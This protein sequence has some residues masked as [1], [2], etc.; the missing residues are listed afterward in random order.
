MAGFAPVAALELPEVSMTIALVLV[1]LPPGCP[2][3]LLSPLC[4]TAVT[5][6]LSAPKGKGSTRRRNGEQPAPLGASRWAAQRCPGSTSTVRKRLRLVVLALLLMRLVLL[7]GTA[8]LVPLRLHLLVRRI[9]QCRHCRRCVPSRL[10]QRPHAHVRLVI[11]HL[12]DLR[13]RQRWFP[14]PWYPGEGF[15]LAADPPSRHCH[16]SRK[17]FIAPNHPHLFHL[18]LLRRR[19]R[20]RVASFPARHRED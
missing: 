9:Q 13:P 20:F 10:L 6:P 17:A 8:P 1:P 14:Q 16:A 5:H 4:D 3:R 7:T 15:E 12:L 2:H 19:Q 11:R 18:L